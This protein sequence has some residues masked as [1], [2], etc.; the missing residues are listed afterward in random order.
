MA[1]VS[2][3]QNAAIRSDCDPLICA[4]TSWLNTRHGDSELKL[5]VARVLTLA[6]RRRASRNP[7]PATTKIGRMSE[8]KIDA[9][10]WMFTGSADRLGEREDRVD[11]DRHGG[12]ARQD[13]GERR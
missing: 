9:M 10:S 13:A 1:I 11:V 12:R 5:T 7:M 4:V 2:S 3:T 6:P 8:A